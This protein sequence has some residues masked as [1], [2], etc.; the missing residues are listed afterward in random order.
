[1]LAAAAGAD[2]SLIVAVILLRT[3]VFLHIRGNAPDS[4]NPRASQYQ[5][6]F[7]VRLTSRDVA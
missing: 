5:A 2:A 7:V 6:F 1:M 4:S 3:V